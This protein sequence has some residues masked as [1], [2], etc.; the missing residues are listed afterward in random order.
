MLLMCYINTDIWM[1]QRLSQLKD[2]E[3]G[4]DEK[5][6][7]PEEAIRTPCCLL[8]LCNP[9]HCLL[10]FHRRCK[11]S[12]VLTVVQPHQVCIMSMKLAFVFLPHR[13]SLTPPLSEHLN[14]YIHLA[15]FYYN[16]YTV[17]AF[18]LQRIVL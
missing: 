8:T 9:L 17:T 6:K 1:T 16:M 4:A 5:K 2:S 7:S 18:S 13:S 10:F 15:E 14:C 3:E 11:D 12:I